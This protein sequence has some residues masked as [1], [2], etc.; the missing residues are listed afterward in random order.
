MVRSSAMGERYVQ[1]GALRHWLSGGG[2]ERVR[3]P[4]QPLL[5]AGEKV[6][7]FGPAAS[8]AGIYWNSWYF[9]VKP[10]Q[11]SKTPVLKARTGFLVFLVFL[12]A[13]LAIAPLGAVALVSGAVTTA[14]RPTAATFARFPRIGAKETPTRPLP[15]FPGFSRLWRF[16]R[17]PRAILVLVNAD[18]L[19]P[20]ARSVAKAIGPGGVSDHGAQ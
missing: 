20:Q 1:D 5:L 16:P 12:R 7:P 17:F 11:V 3:N 19:R 10:R 2:I 14:P 13:S 15:I 4:T 6:S 18:G 9:L 8:S